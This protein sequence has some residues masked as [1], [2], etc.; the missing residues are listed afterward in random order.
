MGGREGERGEKV[1]LGRE[2]GGKKREREKGKT[3]KG[4]GRGRF[5]PTVGGA[6]FPLLSPLSVHTL[7]RRPSVG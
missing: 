2:G 1:G 4:T 6:L 7:F 3:L 5:R